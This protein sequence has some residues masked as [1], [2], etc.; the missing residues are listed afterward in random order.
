MGNE[1]GYEMKPG[2]RYVIR[3]V[4]ALLDRPGEAMIDTQADGLLST[5]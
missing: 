4:L 5:S 2:N 1:H 3:N